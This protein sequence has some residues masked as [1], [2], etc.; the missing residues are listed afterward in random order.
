MHAICKTEPYHPCFTR[1]LSSML[2]QSPII[3]AS[4]E[5]Y[6]PC[7]TRALSSMLYQSP[8][9]HALPEPY[10]SCFTR[11]LSSMLYQRE[12]AHFYPSRVVNRLTRAGIEPIAKAGPQGAC[13]ASQTIGQSSPSTSGSFRP[14]RDTRYRSCASRPCHSLPNLG[15]IPQRR[16]FR[17]SRGNKEGAKRSWYLLQKSGLGEVKEFKARRVHNC[18]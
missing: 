16:K 10:D 12:V 13:S 14:C 18:L 15:T 1:A 17:G 11:A 2:H 6:H 7:F 4:P 5:P 8:I 3:H 9:I